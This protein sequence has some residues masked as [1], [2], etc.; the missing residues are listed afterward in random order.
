MMMGYFHHFYLLACAG[1]KIWIKIGLTP[2]E[3][4][5][6]VYLVACFTKNQF[7]YIVLNFVDE[8]NI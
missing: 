1:Q 7:R 5:N 3:F 2:P 6:I 4:Q 8:K